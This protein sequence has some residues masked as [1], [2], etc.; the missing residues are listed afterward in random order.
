[1][2]SFS[3]GIDNLLE[4]VSVLQGK[5]VGLVAHPASVT[6][7]GAH[8]LDA[9]VDQGVNISRAFGPQHGLR[10]D[11][12]DNMIESEDF[13]DPKHKIPVISLYGQYRY[14]QPDMLDDLDVVLFDLQDVGCRVYT[15]ITTLRYFISACADKGVELWILDRPNPA[16]RP[17]DGL[18]LEDGEQSFVGCDILPMRHGLTVAE[19]ALWFAN[20]LDCTQPTVVPMHEYDPAQGPGFGWPAFHNPWINPSPNASSVNMARCF[21]GTVLLEG[22]TLSE[23]RGTTSAL[24]L[25][26]APDLP[27][28]A[29][30]QQMGGDWGALL[31]PCY[32][33][34][35][36]HKH[37]DALC[38]GI[39]LH[40]D[41]AGYENENFKPF[42]LIANM[43]KCLR[44]IAPDYD[45]WRHHDYEYEAGRNPID[46]INGGAFLRE[47]VDSDN[48][49]PTLLDERLSATQAD[50]LGKREPYL[51]Y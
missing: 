3:L 5:R 30:L 35:T 31:R 12:Q 29:I 48:M 39:Q 46:V 51:L 28:E 20:Q 32:F 13:V 9:L 33:T 19:L 49:G 44:R 38:K 17:V 18:Y 23:G 11:K 22:T 10:G 36:F 15:Y 27:V 40:T 25:I 2:S 37:A 47:W 43:L 24:E 42:R 45:L 34:P 7:P 50:W 4:N 8:S 41:Y 1:V 26:G 16:G 14:P 6:R 21:S